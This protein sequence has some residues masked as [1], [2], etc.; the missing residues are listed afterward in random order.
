MKD[1]PSDA[2]HIAAAWA[3]DIEVLPIPVLPWRGKSVEKGLGDTNFFAQYINTAMDQPPVHD[4]LNHGGLQSFL[5]LFS[6]P[7]RIRFSC[8]KP[9]PSYINNKIKK[10]SL[11]VL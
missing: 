2:W 8:H 5:Y 6:L 9:S 7:L 4:T 3:A 10:Q 11:F 1:L